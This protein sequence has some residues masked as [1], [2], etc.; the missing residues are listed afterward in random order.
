MFVPVPIP[1]QPIREIPIALHEVL[2][3]ECRILGFQ[4]GSST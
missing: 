1:L 2:V 4:A 3:S